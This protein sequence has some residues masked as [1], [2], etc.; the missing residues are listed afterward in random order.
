MAVP[1]AAPARIFGLAGVVGAEGSCSVSQRMTG[2]IAGLIVTAVQQE[3][4][5]AGTMHCGCLVAAG[6]PRK[7]QMR[8]SQLGSVFGS[9][10]ALLH[11]HCATCKRRYYLHESTGATTSIARSHAEV[12]APT[13]GTTLPQH[14]TAATVVGC[15]AA[16]RPCHH[17]RSRDPV[18]IPMS[19]LPLSLSFPRA[20]L[21]PDACPQPSDWAARCHALPFSS[22]LHH[23]HAC[24]VAS[25]EL[26]SGQRACLLAHRPR[27]IW[28]SQTYTLPCTGS[29]LLRRVLGA[30]QL[31]VPSPGPGCLLGLA[32]A[33]G[34]LL[35]ILPA[36]CLVH[37]SR[38]RIAARASEACACL[39]ARVES[40]CL[41]CVG[42]SDT[43]K[44]DGHP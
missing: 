41:R 26:A 18:A 28:M 12:I 9:A 31:P 8:C 44:P 33:C 43:I 13:C 24:H 40:A 10:P 15:S 21:C 17:S 36:L 22:C 42:T 30:T 34:S 23:L 38:Q 11:W 19:V 29:T 32:A 37:R 14:A 2:V 4:F 39:C 3:I 20:C 7:S 35:R 6:Q 1:E 5:V 16:N 27:P 25:S